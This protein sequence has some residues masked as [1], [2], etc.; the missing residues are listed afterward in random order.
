MPTDSKDVAVG[1]VDHRTDQGRAAI[2]SHDELSEILQGL[3]PR[4]HLQRSDSDEELRLA[5]M[6]RAIKEEELAA[7]IA[8]QKIRKMS[9]GAHA[10]SGRMPQT[11]RTPTS[12]VSPEF[13]ST[14]EKVAEVQA[15]IAAETQQAKDAT[16][17]NN[18]AQDDPAVAAA[19]RNADAEKM[20]HESAEMQKEAAEAFAAAQAAKAAAEE[21]MASIIKESAE[22]VRQAEAQAAQQATAAE[23][24]HQAIAAE[25]AQ[26]ATAEKEQL[27]AAEQAGKDALARPTS[28]DDTN[29]D[30]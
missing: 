30:L 27:A 23:A 7:T 15:E 26:R 24:A 29:F 25:A 14:P 4:T 3:R 13:E 19:A 2:A 22:A 5:K 1:R 6:K 12:N 17:Q 9:E 11:P 10:S 8:E 28:N 18:G 16:K 20:I 21:I